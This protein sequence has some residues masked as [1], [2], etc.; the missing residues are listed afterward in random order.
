MLTSSVVLYKTRAD[1]LSALID[2]VKKSEV[3]DKIYFVD[4][5]PDESLREV[6]EDV[7][8]SEYIFN[9]KNIGY[10][11]AHNIAIKKAVQEK[12]EYHIVLNPDI[13]FAPDVLPKL[14]EFMDGNSDAV[15]VLPKVV[16]PNG[17]LQ[18]LCK[19]LPTPFDLIFRR[20]MPKT[21]LIQKMNDRYTLKMSCYDKI[22][23]PPC[24]SGC[25]MFMRTSA[26]EKNNIFFD[27]RY[28]MYCEDFDLIR[29]LHRVGKTLFYPDVTIIHD[30]AK[31]SYKNK[32]MLL[33]HIKSAVKYFNKFGWFFD[34][35]RWEM[36]KKVLGE[37]R[38]L[39]S[40]EIN[41][42]YKIQVK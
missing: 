19:L 6:C 38:E 4:N 41:L 34:K 2:C 8:K 10:G 3:M 14:V 13:K 32:K 23:N 27:D 31:E 33:E 20:F 5:S 11:A 7:E 36:N 26:L 15:Y 30:H 12:S 1:Q 25:F 9:G 17:E 39:E 40:N 37:M 42:K 24:L 35:E 21:K 29:R 28:F 16:Y 18:Y 22:M